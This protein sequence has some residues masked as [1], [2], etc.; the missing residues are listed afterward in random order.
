MTLQNFLREPPAWLPALAASL[1]LAL[2]LGGCATGVAS[3]TQQGRVGPDDGSDSCHAQ[4]VA[5][6]N[7]GSFFGQD[8]LTG[9]AIGA[10]GGAIIGGLAGGNLQDALIGAAAGGAAGAAG[11]YWAALEQQ[12]QDEA[13]L[14]STVTNNLTQENAQIDATQIAFNNDMDC[15]FQQAQSIRA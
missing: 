3:F 7:T 5:L 2:S 9:A 14:E 11:G 12:H 13:G 8:I 10:A 15:R 1:A 6:D 4:A